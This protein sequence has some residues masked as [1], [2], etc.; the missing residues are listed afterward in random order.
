METEVHYISSKPALMK[1]IQRKLMS[2]ED[3]QPFLIKR[4]YWKINTKAINQLRTLQVGKD[5]LNN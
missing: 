4:R 1:I 3:Q 2:L 5:Y